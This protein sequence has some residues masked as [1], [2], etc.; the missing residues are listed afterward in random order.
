MVLATDI[1]DKELSTN[2]KSRWASAFAEDGKIPVHDE[3]DAN[4]KATL[5]I[6]H[7]IQASAVSHT[8]QHWQ[9]YLH[10]NEKFFLELFHAFKAGR[11]TTDPCLGW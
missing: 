5:V 2:R 10:W 1:C 11:S 8:M 3:S 7:L 6:E 4:R 9:I